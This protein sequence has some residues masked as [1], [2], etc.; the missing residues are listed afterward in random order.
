MPEPVEF[1]RLQER[2][3]NVQGTLQRIKALLAEHEKRVAP[4]HKRPK[5]TV[6]K[7][8]L[9][10]LLGPFAVVAHQVRDHAAI[11][12][13]SVVLAVSG[14]SAALLAELPGPAASPPVES[15]QQQPDVQAPTPPGSG[16]VSLP[17]A[18]PQPTGETPT[19]TSS[20][21]PPTSTMLLVDDAVILEPTAT[22]E[23]LLPAEPAPTVT[24]TSTPTPTMAPLTQSEAVAYCL[25]ML[26]T[27][28]LGLPECVAD[29][30]L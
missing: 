30:K 2:I 4:Q 7:G 18:S 12:T 10:A 1:D 9:A 23:P 21:T 15:V 25:S 6:I 28:P 8:G 20:P 27:P 11:A 5:L 17:S 29:L 16:W 24:L 26:P 3:D 14:G 22:P 13:T 19:P